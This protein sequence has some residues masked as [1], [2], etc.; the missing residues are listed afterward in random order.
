MAKIA[1]I[2]NTEEQFKNKNILIL[3]YNNDPLF[4]KFNSPVTFFSW[5]SKNFFKNVV[6]NESLEK[7][8]KE[9]NITHIIYNSDHTIEKYE[10]F[11]KDH[12]N[13]FSNEI[14]SLYGFTV[15]EVNLQNASK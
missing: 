12:P 3:S 5:H 11:F 13:T 8:V 9:M 10:R 2:V 4:Y 7:T 14:F 15:A 6:K 1:D